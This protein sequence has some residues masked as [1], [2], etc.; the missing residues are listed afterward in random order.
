MIPISE[1]QRV[2][3]DRAVSVMTAR[4]RM[5]EAGYHDIQPVA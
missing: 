4:Q 5:R 1:L 3:N 2:I